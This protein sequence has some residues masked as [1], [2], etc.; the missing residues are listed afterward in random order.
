[1]HMTWHTPD[2]ATAPQLRLVDIAE[3]AG[4]GFALIVN[5]R[6]DGEGEDQPPSELLQTEAERLGLEYA[7][8]P[9][10]PGELTDREARDFADLA[11]Q[12]EGPVLAF[13]RTGNRSQKLW[14]RAVELGLL[15]N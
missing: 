3:C 8:L 10:V 7:Y 6:P 15:Q 12:A 2:F 1:M 11:S 4:R 5:N 13:C 9:I 14:N